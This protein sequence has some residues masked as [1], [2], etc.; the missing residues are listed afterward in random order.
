MAK[1]NVSVRKPKLTTHEGAPAK[2]INAE[3]ELRRSVMSCMLWEGTFYES[4]QDIADRIAELTPKV[5]G[6]IVRDIAV[7][8]RTKMKLRHAPLWIARAMAADKNQ[9][10]YVG[11][12]LPRIIQRADEMAEFLAMYWK[13]GRTP[14]AKQI[15]KGLANAFDKFDA[16]QFAKYKGIG[17]QVTLRDVMFLVRPKPANKEREALYK[18]IADNT[19]PIPQTWENR[20]SAGQDKKTVWETMLKERE[21]GA[22]AL[23]RNLN[24]MQKVGVNEQLIFDALDAMNVQ[25]VLPYRFIAAA[26]FVPQWESHLETAMLKCL[27]GLSKL[28]GKT[29]ILVDV[30]GSMH[31]AISSKS[32]LMRYDAANGLA[33]LARELCEQVA[34]YSFSN[35]LKRVPDRRGFALRDAITNSQDHGGTRLGDA[36]NNLN[37]HE[38]YDRL[39]VLTDEQSHDAVPNPKA[40][41]YMVN[42][43]TDKNGVGYGDWTH[44]DGFSEAI[45]TYIAASEGVSLPNSDD[46]Q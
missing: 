42:V 23:L 8:A 30:S 9:R 27:A 44:I 17:D 7:E 31:S 3:L 14:I 20:L 28:P 38:A 12:L 13:D 24:N 34:V 22:L 1:T 33:I 10:G 25:R 45:F 2:V 5:D 43:S 35:A 29:V 39:I 18:Q 40:K 6:K 19:L 41:G 46:N 16:Y 36:V 37:S 32:D 4:G 26:R 21:L 11:D 15:R